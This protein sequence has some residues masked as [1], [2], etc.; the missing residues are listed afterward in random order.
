MP[1]NGS[2]EVNHAPNVLLIL[3]RGFEDLEAV[4]MLDVCGWTQYRAHLPDVRVRVT[5]FLPEK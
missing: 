5:G 1:Q 4:T 3:G 2:A